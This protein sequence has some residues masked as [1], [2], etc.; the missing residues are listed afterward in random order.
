MLLKIRMA[1]NKPHVSN[2][3]PVRSLI[4]DYLKADIPLF[5]SRSLIYVD[6]IAELHVVE[7]MR[8][9]VREAKVTQ[10]HR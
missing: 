4:H 6:M 7:V 9:R 1:I 8:H 5:M 3:V 10:G 2:I